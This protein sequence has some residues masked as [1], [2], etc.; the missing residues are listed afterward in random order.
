MLPIRT[1][2]AAAL[3]LTAVPALAAPVA[4]EPAPPAQQ[5]APPDKIAPPMK[6]PAK[7]LKPETS[8]QAPQELKPDKGQNV[9]IP[10]SPNE[11]TTTKCGDASQ[12]EQTLRSARCP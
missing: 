8:G 2:L 9:Q 5:A 12:Q 3:V 10:S 11:A 4:P 1:L 7:P 6:V